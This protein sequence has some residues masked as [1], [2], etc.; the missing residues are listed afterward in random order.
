MT[1]MRRPKPSVRR[2]LVY[3]GL[4]ALATS[5]LAFVGLVA[6]FGALVKGPRPR[7]TT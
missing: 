4:R 2:H 6:V 7:T 5:L 1:A 3:A